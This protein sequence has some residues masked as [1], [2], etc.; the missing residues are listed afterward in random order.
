MSLP[1]TPSFQHN[2]LTLIKRLS[3][4]IRPSHDLLNLDL[5]PAVELDSTSCII[6]WYEIYTHGG[7]YKNA[8]KI[9]RAY[10]FRIKRVASEKI[11]AIN[12]LF[13]Y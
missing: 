10:P 12:A 13:F 9:E 8:Y 11:A 1:Q 5:S 6:S 3:S 7:I 2:Q 4:L